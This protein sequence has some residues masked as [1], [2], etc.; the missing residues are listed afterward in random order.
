M[1]SIFFKSYKANIDTWYALSSA[2][3]RETLKDYS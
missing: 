3:M 2:N 1:L